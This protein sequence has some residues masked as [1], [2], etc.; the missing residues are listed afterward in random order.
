MCITS[1]TDQNQKTTTYSYDDA[2]RLTAVT[3]PANN[4]TY[5]AYDTEDNLSSNTTP[6]ITPRTSPTTRAAG[7][8][9]W[10]G[11]GRRITWDDRS[12][13]AGVDRGQGAQGGHW[14]DENSDNRWDA[15]GSPLPGS[16][17]RQASSMESVPQPGQY[18]PAAPSPM[19]VGAWGTTMIIVYTILSALG[20]AW[21]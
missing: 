21:N 8:R 13:G 18:L 11:N 3:D 16:Q 2:D 7:S 6:T 19:T 5:Y 20:G 1:V 12:H 10:E 4:T 17:N 14:D 9:Y 15:N